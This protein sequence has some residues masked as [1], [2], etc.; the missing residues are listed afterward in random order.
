MNDRRND[1]LP[2]VQ[3]PWPAIR[4]VQRKDTFK[5][6]VQQLNAVGDVRK[7]S[8]GFDGLGTTTWR[9]VARTHPA[10]ELGT[11]TTVS[12]G[13]NLV[14]MAKF[15]YET[16]ADGYATMP[17]GTLGLLFPRNGTY[18]GDLSFD[19][20]M[21]LA[22]ADNP[23]FGPTAGRSGFN[24]QGA[25]G[26]TT[27][28]RIRSLTKLAGVDNDGEIVPA[29]SL[30]PVT[31]DGVNVQV[32]NLTASSSAN[33][34]VNEQ[35]TMLNAGNG[36]PTAQGVQAYFTDWEVTNHCWK[37]ISGTLHWQFSLE[38][39]T[40]ADSPD[41]DG[42]YHAIVLVPYVFQDAPVVN[43]VDTSEPTCL[44][45]PEVYESTEWCQ[46]RATIC[47]YPE[48]GVVNAFDGNVVY[49]VPVRPTA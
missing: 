44:Y 28:Y 47:S 13:V 33:L 4:D 11:S 12:H 29:T 9:P 36:F 43:T 14:K 21:N 31:I 18:T 19:R 48:M 3:V 24:Q 39:N 1:Y 41:P 49:G 25:R 17:A 27:A 42:Y 30:V 46:F 6:L 40:Y 45:M 23:R 26:F 20:V 16:V 37:T 32:S 15:L 38:M 35:A 22:A 2:F 7:L 34:H 8:V 5:P 10:V